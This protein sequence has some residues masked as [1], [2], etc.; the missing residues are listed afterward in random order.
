MKNKEVII[1][2]GLPGSGKSTY[3]NNLKQNVFYDDYVICSTD[4]LLEN[5]AADLNISYNEAHANH[6]T[7]SIEREF[8]EE[9]WSAIK[10]DKNVIIDRTNLSV[11][12]RNKML[13]YFNKNYKK[14]AVSFDVTNIEEI[15]KRITNRGD[16]KSIPENILMKLAGSYEI[17]TLEQF[18]EIIT[19]KI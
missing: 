7:K 1:M 14:I 2:V 3:I 8:K 10:E 18:D 17:P 9:I 4:Q 12:S 13:S 19:V 5:I 11:K 15:K 16:H 6:Y